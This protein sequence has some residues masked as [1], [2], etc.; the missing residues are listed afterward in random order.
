MSMQAPLV[1]LSL[2]GLFAISPELCNQLRKAIMPKQVLNETVSTHVLI[3]QVPDEVSSSIKLNIQSVNDETHVI[4]SPER[5]TPLCVYL[6][7]CDLPDPKLLTFYNT[8]HTPA[9]SST[10]AS[11]HLT[12]YTDLFLSTKRKYKPVAKKVHPVIGELPEK[13]CI[14]HK[15]IDNPLDDL[16][17][18]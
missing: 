10:F 2:E 17:V 7:V 5:S 8:T 12:P 15:I 18:L 11:E 9:D 16:P 3:E 4:W 14:E 1:T 6:A 13:F